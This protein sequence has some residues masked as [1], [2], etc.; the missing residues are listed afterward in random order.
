M[1]SVARK[2]ADLPDVVRRTAPIDTRLSNA[3][4]G[5]CPGHL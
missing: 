1:M 4:T 2:Y 3:I 5:S